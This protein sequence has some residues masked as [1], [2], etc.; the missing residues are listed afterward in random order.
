MKITNILDQRKN[1]ITLENPVPCEDSL[2]GSQGRPA[3]QVFPGQKWQKEK[4]VIYHFSATSDISNPS[5]FLHQASLP[6]P[7]IEPSL[8]ESYLASTAFIKKLTVQTT[9]AHSQIMTTLRFLTSSA[10]LRFCLA[11]YLLVVANAC[12]GSIRALSATPLEKDEASASEHDHRPHPRHLADPHGYGYD[13]NDHLHPSATAT[14]SSRSGKQRRGQEILDCGTPPMSLEELQAAKEKTESFWERISDPDFSDG[15]GNWYFPLPASPSA[16]AEYIIPVYYHVIKRSDGSS[17]S[18]T[19]TSVDRQH[20]ILN[21]AF[22]RLGIQFE[23][24]AATEIVNDRWYGYTVFNSDAELEMKTQLRQGGPETLNV[25]INDA[26]G[27]CG[28]AYFPSE[29][30]KFP[31]WDGVV[32]NDECFADGP[33]PIK[34][35]DTMVHEVGHWLGVPHTFEGACITGDGIDDTPDHR[36]PTIGC[37]S[38]PPDTCKGRPGSDPI[39]N[40]MNYADDGCRNEFSEG[41]KQRMVAELTQYREPNK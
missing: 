3:L 12:G 16:N 26:I 17:P 25:Y 13:H 28:Y 18:P 40:Y 8:K 38:V 35:G 21:D 31:Q 15:E 19:L 23:K 30:D 4:K 5:F 6:L 37:P 9:L 22:R 41:Q 36:E 2:H 29:Y 27:F 11:G 33:N 1:D 39:A 10:L 7:S 24:K 20:R 14:A 34:Q 32:I